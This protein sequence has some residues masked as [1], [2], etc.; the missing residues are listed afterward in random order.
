MERRV[1]ERKQEK[2]RRKKK[3]GEK[4][5]K[6]DNE[7][8]GAWVIIKNNKHKNKGKREEK[9]GKRKKKWKAK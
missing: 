7:R 4:S 1:R 3:K 5:W 9:G 2:G 8:Y 6:N